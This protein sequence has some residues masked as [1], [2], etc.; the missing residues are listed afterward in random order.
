MVYVNQNTDGAEVQPTFN[1]AAGY[2]TDYMTPYVTSD[3]PGDDL[4]QYTP[5]LIGSSYTVPARAVVTLVS[6]TFNE[7]ND[8]KV[9]PALTGS[10]PYTLGSGV[11]TIN[12]GQGT[13]SGVLSGAGGIRKSGSGI[14]T[15]TAQN[16][17]SGDTIINGGTLEIAGGIGASGTS[18]IDIQSGTAILKTVNVNKT[19][20]DITNADLA[21]FEVADGTHKV[22]DITGS[23]TTQVDSGASLT[24][25]SISQGTLTIGSGATVT[26]QAI[27]GG[28][29]ALS[30]NLTSVPEPSTLVLIGV[31]AISLLA[32]A[33]RRRKCGCKMPKRT[34]Q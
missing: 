23:G 13:Y 34:D 9:F 22:G 27:P 1:G 17:Y 19:D 5:F 16:T 15:L 25:A 31:G 8:G 33:W 12:P 26:I 14:F 18:L 4:K 24:A 2:Q 6:G 28:P 7:N 10:V 21:V 32:Y 29:L 3:T 20:L 30:D 11:L